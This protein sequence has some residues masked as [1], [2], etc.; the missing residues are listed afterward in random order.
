[1]K[2]RIS[3]WTIIVDIILIV[4]GIGIGLLIAD[5]N[6]VP[7]NLNESP[8]TVQVNQTFGEQIDDN[9]VL[10]NDELSTIKLFENASPSV[11]Y[12]TTS[13]VRRDYWTMDVTEVPR[14]T[15]SAF[16]WNKDGHII[17]NYHVIQGADKA[18][19]TLAD[20]STWEAELIGAAPEKD[21]AVLKIDAPKDVLTP[22]SRGNSMHKL[23]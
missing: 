9:E 19:V 17:T 13:N 7:E 2:R 10:N 3:I 15:G 14:G 22:I 5:N 18:T 4:I 6:D 1:M 23:L 8:Q 20:R 21:L 12:I 11:A 16:I